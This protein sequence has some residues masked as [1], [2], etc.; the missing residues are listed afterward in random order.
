MQTTRS[1]ADGI[2]T[3]SVGTR[4]IRPR[5]AL[6][7]LALAVIVQSPWISGGF[8]RQDEAKLALAARL[9]DVCPPDARFVAIG[10]GMMSRTRPTRSRISSSD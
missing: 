4:G 6:G 10:P 2:P 5:L 9:R 3:R 8:F 7:A 1:V